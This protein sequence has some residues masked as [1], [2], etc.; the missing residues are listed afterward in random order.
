M[1]GNTEMEVQLDKGISGFLTGKNSAP[2]CMY[3]VCG[4][5]AA[6]ADIGVRSDEAQWVF[7][8]AKQGPRSEIWGSGVLPTGV[9]AQ[10]PARC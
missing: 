6:L 8:R 4:L 5:P 2:W 3:Q 9:P 7:E 10:V 1:H